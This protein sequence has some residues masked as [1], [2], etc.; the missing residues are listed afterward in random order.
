MELQTRDHTSSSY[1]KSKKNLYIGEYGKTI[2]ED[3]AKEFDGLEKLTVNTTQRRASFFIALIM[4]WS[5][6]FGY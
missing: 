3:Y 2:Y 6:S 4:I 1:W 5:P